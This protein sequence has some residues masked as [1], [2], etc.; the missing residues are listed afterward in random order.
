MQKYLVGFIQ[1]II[2]RYYN[3]LNNLKVK[4]ILN[5]LLIMIY[6][7]KLKLD[8]GIKNKIKKNIRNIKEKI[9]IIKFFKLV[10]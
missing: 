8:Y 10:N 3:I 4:N 9:K 2:R 1:D 5:K 6:F 7:I